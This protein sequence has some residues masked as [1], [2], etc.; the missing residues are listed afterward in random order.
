MKLQTQR[1]NGTWSDV[2]KNRVNEFL[3]MAVNFFSNKDINTRQEAVMAIESGRKLYYD[4]DWYAQI[5]NDPDENVEKG[6]ILFCQKC[7]KPGYSGSYPFSTPDSDVCDDCMTTD[8]KSVLDETVSI[9]IADN[10]VGTRKQWSVKIDEWFKR[11]YEKVNPQSEIDS[12]DW[13]IK[14]MDVS[15]LLANDEE[16]EVYKRLE[17][18]YDDCKTKYSVDGYEN[19]GYSIYRNNKRLT[20]YR[21][22]KNK[23]L[24][25]ADLLKQGMDIEEA[26]NITG[27]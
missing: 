9:Y 12:N 7:F 2:E 20:L 21:Y 22:T 6:E 11:W 27:Q 10:L 3:D 26:N 8:D 25:V 5:R 1:S 14:K 13:K 18:V 15:L 16:I 24:E 19:T 4:T 23:A 17:D